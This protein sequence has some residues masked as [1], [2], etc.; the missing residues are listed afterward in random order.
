MPKYSEPTRTDHVTTFVYLG[1][2]VVAV[3]AGAFTFLPHYWYLWAAAI[4][5][6]LY[7]L[8]AYDVRNSGYRCASCGNEFEIS[9]A[10][11]L[12]T[13]HGVGKDRGWKYLKCPR[14]G[15]WSRATVLKKVEDSREDA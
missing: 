6:G 7:L 2:F 1:L 13:I 14:C 4:V 11:D 15:K 10:T 12:V 9:I 5:A 8:V 3:A